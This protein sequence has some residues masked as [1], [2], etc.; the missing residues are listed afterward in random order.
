MR[1]ERSF[2]SSL[3]ISM[4]R[5][6]PSMIPQWRPC[7]TIGSKRYCPLGLLPVG[8]RIPRYDS[9]WNGSSWIHSYPTLNSISATPVLVCERILILPNAQP[10]CWKASV[11]FATVVSPITFKTPPPSLIIFSS[12]FRLFDTRSTGNEILVKNP[13][14]FSSS[15]ESALRT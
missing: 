1:N 7:P 2:A 6:L 10:S 15:I 5:L 11:I 4:P 8:I 13:R 9:R 14:P 3:Q 12:K